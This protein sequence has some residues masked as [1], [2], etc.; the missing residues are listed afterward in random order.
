[1]QTPGARTVDTESSSPG[2]TVVPHD[3]RPRRRLVGDAA[4]LVGLA[5]VAITQPVLDLFGNN[6][7]FFVAGNYGRRQIVMFVLVVALVPAAIVFA[8]TAPARLAGRTA[9][10]VAHAVGVGLFTA[11]FGLVLCQT[12]GIDAAVLAFALALTLG[13]GVALAEM[14]SDAMRR[15]LMYLAVGNVA[16]IALFA[17]T[18]PTSALLGGT[19]YADEGNVSGPPLQGPVTLV[20]LDEFPLTAILRPDGTI[21]DSLYPNLA[22]LAGQSTWFR[23]ASAE[24]I[25]TYL[26][27]PS[28]MTGNDTEEG[29][30]PIY[31]DHPRNIFTL[32][33][34]RYPVNNY[35]VVTD[36]CPPDTCARPPGQP[37][38][39]ALADA[40]VVYRHRVL[41]SSLRDGLPAVDQGW[42]NF[43]EGIGGD[44]A[45]VSERTVVTTSS[46]EADPLARMEEVPEHEGGRHGQ[47]YALR[48]EL[49]EIGPEPA[50]NFVHALLPHHPYEL[51]TWGVRSSDTWVPNELPSPGDPNHDRFFAELYGQQ[52]MQIAVVDGIV[53]EMMAH[54]QATGAWDTGTLIVVSDHGLSTRPTEF[55]RDLT[56]ENQDEVLRIPLFV[57]TPGQTSG[58]IRDDPA[59]TL[60]VLP[61]LI[62]LL[63]IDTDWV[64][65]GHSL[66]D[67]SEPGYDRLLTTDVDDMLDY[68]EERQAFLRPGQGWAR[69]LGIGEHSDLVGTRVA[70]HEVGEPSDFTWSFDG[71]DALAA[72]DAAGGVVPV[73]LNGDVHGGERAPS[74]DLVVALDGVISGT[75][76]GCLP[77][78]GGGWRCTGLLGPEVEGGADEVVAYEVERRGDVVTLHPLV[79]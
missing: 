43:G 8:L 41:P 75:A 64:M 59:T 52:A 20:V 45:P 9:G 58:E 79:T 15:F 69:I 12:L 21:D 77:L 27:V 14:R 29:M 40:S 48:R 67:G 44:G 50:V 49:L 17:F 68:V 76:G 22:A 11:L 25:H 78:D 39:Q 66:F 7:T 36:L 57:R 54:L 19:F 60:D 72:P 56:D 30:L 74:S 73:L 46:G 35:E 51:T 18:S 2:E 4:V 61:S 53:G 1:M 37:L 33:G 65:A 38:S 28:I 34:G 42:G 5:G 24:T 10:A 47:A 71:A 32:F 23:N 70:D 13:V 63:D 6:P 16:F 31:E 55:T 62:D 26:S 3:T